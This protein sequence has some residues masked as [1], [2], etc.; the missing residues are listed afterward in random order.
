MV[1][2]SA[3]EKVSH[4]VCK[5][6]GIWKNRYIVFS[7]IF[8]FHQPSFRSHKTKISKNSDF[9]FLCVC[10]RKCINI[11]CLVLW[12]C[13]TNSSWC[14][15]NRPFGPKGLSSIHFHWCESKSHQIKQ[16]QTSKICTKCRPLVGMRTWTSSCNVIGKDQ[17]KYQCMNLLIHSKSP[18]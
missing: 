17:S 9:I 3:A 1:S 18:N 12:C 8:V 14:T 16:T 13:H 5:S 11:R 4:T 6:K 7:C 2:K 15:L 10:K